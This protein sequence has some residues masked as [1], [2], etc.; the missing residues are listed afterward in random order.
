MSNG[1]RR[2]NI[3][4]GL[5]L[6][7]TERFEKLPALNAVIATDENSNAAAHLARNLANR[8]WELLGTNAVTADIAFNAAGGVDLATHGGASDSAIFLPHLDTGQ[9]AWTG[10]TW[11]PSKQP[12]FSCVFKTDAA[13]TN[14][15]IWCGFKL[16]NTPVSTT[17]ADI[18]FFRFQAGTDTNW[19]C[20]SDIANAGPTSTD[21]GVA[22]AAAT[23]YRMWITID[24]NR[25]ARFYI[26]GGLVATTAALTSTAAFIPYIGVLSAVDA[27]VK[28][29]I[30]KTVECSVVIA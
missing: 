29:I 20:V 26:N 24:A 19:Q 27:T 2:E 8:N 12:H 13:L 7:L 21:S 3:H 10:T 11:L 15:T 17:D 5:R 18:A 23:V 9:T 28:K 25:I 22:V 4:D 6:V 1:P 30:L 16:T 14:T